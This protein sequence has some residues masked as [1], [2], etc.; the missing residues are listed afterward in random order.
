[1][2]KFIFLL[3]ASIIIFGVAA[4]ENQPLQNNEQI[5]QVEYTYCQLL[6][7]SKFLST[8]IYVE[9]DFG[10]ENSFWKNTRLLKDENGKLVTFNSMVD[11]LNFMGNFGWEFVQA[12]VVTTNNQ[13]VYHWLLRIKKNTKLVEP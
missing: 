2:K 13:N 6:G 4:Q 8:K 11:A 1:M 12:Y 5:D 9:I 10:Q 3:L 7:T